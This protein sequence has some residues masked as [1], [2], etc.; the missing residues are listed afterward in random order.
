MERFRLHDFSLGL[1]YPGIKVREDRR[2]HFG[3][4]SL[5]WG[6]GRGFMTLTRSS[7]SA[8]WG[9]ITQNAIT[10]SSR[11]EMDYFLLLILTLHQC[12]VKV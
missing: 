9:Q 4:L 11:L 1:I 5:R 6:T 8:K 7:P 2:Q 3:A 12:R 10:F